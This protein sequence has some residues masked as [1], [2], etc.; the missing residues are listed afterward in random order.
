MRELSLASLAALLSLLGVALLA[1][2]LAASQKTAHQNLTPSAYYHDRSGKESFADIQAESVIGAEQSRLRSFTFEGADWAWVDT[3]AINE[4]LD[5]LLLDAAWLD[6]V[7]VFFV[8]AS[9]LFRSFKAGDEA[10]FDQRPIAY[11]KPAIP[12][13]R[14]LG[15]EAVESVVFRLSAQGVFALPL[16][17]VSATE[18]YERS[19]NTY[20]YYGAWLA[21]LLALSFY[22]AVMFFYLRSRVHFYY[23]LYVS[24]FAALLAVA[25]GLTQQY[26]WPKLEGI[27]THAANTALALTNFGTAI[28]VSKFLGLQRNTWRPTPLLMGLSYLSLLCVPIAFFVGYIALI[29][30][31]VASVG[32]MLL[33]LAASATMTLRGNRIAP[34]LY[35]SQ[36]ILIPCNTIGLLRFLGL[37]Y[38][39]SWTDHVA[40]IGM[41]ADA[42]IL[43][44]A[45]AY[46]VSGLR[47][48][49]DLAVL[50]REQSR[51]GHARNVYNAKNEEQQRIGKALHDS[52]GHKML[53]VK[54]AIAAGSPQAASGDKLTLTELIDDAIDEVRD[55][56]HLLY[57]SII[58]NIGL[59]NAIE[60]IL[61][62]GFQNHSANYEFA[63]DDASLSS[64][65]KVLLYRAAQEFTSN[66]LKHSTASQF[67]LTLRIDEKTRAVNMVAKDN[68]TTP[69]A[70]ATAGF[71]L[72]M[73]AQQ[74]SMLEGSLLIGRDMKDF[75][76]IT[77]SFVDPGP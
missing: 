67:Q 73:L 56:S 12:I 46:Q 43:S 65:A 69:F 55:L 4:D 72:S 21:V 37:L 63:I 14:T 24:V 40:E 18:F 77:L 44:F 36:L 66:F 33:C 29:P 13:V 9:G 62:K 64:E 8:T 3:D 31:L 39:Q 34:F 35:A 76:T 15:D 11:L 5:I 49:R 53:L 23:L 68:G 70:T 41:G 74:A 17:A 19:T 42:I 7:D 28:F 25:G 50:Q 57:P 10:A 6:E 58:E 54:N 22:N 32:I 27:T 1:Q 48:E 71:G 52:L 61:R 60:S 20:F 51:L 38:D 30:I 2:T 45:L 47:R 59:K 75:N 16:Q 26:L